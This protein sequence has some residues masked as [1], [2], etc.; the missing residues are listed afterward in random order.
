MSSLLS[1]RLAGRDA[2]TPIHPSPHRRK[3]HRSIVCTALCASRLL[4][5]LFVGCRRLSCWRTADVFCRPSCRFHGFYLSVSCR[6]SRIA[7]CRPA[8]VVSCRLFGRACPVFSGL[9][10]TILR[11]VY[12]HV[13]CLVLRRTLFWGFALVSCRWQALT[14]VPRGI[15]RARGFPCLVSCPLRLRCREPVGNL[16]E[17][18]RTS[19]RLLPCHRKSSLDLVSYRLFC[20]LSCRRT[21]EVLCRPSCRLRGFCFSVSCRVSRSSRVLFRLSCYTPFQIITHHVIV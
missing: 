18:S 2:W 3:A 11:A 21:A 20:R 14:E 7:A 17:T 6:V 10:P 1:G 15:W 4:C 19:C 13:G 12:S 16:S 9:N 5:R 8:A